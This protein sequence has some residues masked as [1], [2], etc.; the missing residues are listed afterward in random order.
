MPGEGIF[1]GE[2]LASPFKA[3]NI[4]FNLSTKLLSIKVSWLIPGVKY[5]VEAADQE[6]GPFAAVLPNIQ[7]VS[8]GMYTISV[9][10][11]NKP[12]Y[13]IRKQ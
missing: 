4:T 12:V 3:A 5:I 10:N 6:S 8:T 13:R 1:V 7:T 9:P 11:A 2:P